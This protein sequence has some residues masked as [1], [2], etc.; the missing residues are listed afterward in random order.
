[1]DMSLVKAITNFK[2]MR[3]FDLMSWELL[4]PKGAPSVAASVPVKE[5]R[6][7]K[8]SGAPLNQILYGPPGTGKTYNVVKYA[9]ELIEGDRIPSS[10]PYADIRARYDRYAATGQI[11]FTS[12]IDMQPEVAVAF[13]S[14]Y[15]KMDFTEFD[16]YVKASLEDFLNLHNGIFLVN[17][18]NNYSMELTLEP[19]YHDEDPVL[20]LTEDSFVIPVIYPFGTI[21]LLLTI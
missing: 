19:P 17:M 2:N 8:T 7:R 15:A 16:E 21:F 20:K 4:D 18:S 9:V 11:K 10:V 12:M 3:V 6:V 5:E 13:A 14:R 1:M